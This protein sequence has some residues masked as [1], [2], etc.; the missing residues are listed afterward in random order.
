M[1]HLL[2][3]RY[4]IAA[5]SALLI[6]ACSSGCNTWQP[7]AGWNMFENKS[8]SEIHAKAKKDP[9]PAASEPAAETIKR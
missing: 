5:A 2:V 6:A 3:S 7:Q 8:D 1:Q 4:K 9:F